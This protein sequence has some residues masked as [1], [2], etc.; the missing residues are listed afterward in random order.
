VEQGRGGKGGDSEGFR[1]GEGYVGTP[2]LLL[3][4]EFLVTRLFVLTR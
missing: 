1:E 2:F 4:I 3:H